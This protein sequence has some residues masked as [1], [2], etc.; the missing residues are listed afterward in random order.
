MG[1]GAIEGV[2]AHYEINRLTPFSAGFNYSRFDL[3]IA[4]PR[5]VSALGG[6][7]RKIVKVVGFSAMEASVEHDVTDVM[8]GDAL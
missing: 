4:A 2:P 8:A 1:E 6:K 7:K 5:N 3:L